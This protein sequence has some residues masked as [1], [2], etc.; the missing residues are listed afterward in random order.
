MVTRAKPSRRHHDRFD[1]PHIPAGQLGQQ[2]WPRTLDELVEIFRA[3]TLRGEPVR[4]AG[5]ATAPNLVITKIGTGGKVCLYTQ[6]PT[7]LITDINGWF[8]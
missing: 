5:S 1:S 2:V 4:V 7:D 8:P 3:A 6:N